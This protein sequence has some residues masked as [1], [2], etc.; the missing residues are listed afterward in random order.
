ML[1]IPHL[2]TC[3]PSGA[4]G[5]L[6]SIDNNF[7]AAAPFFPHFLPAAMWAPPR[8]PVLQEV[9]ACSGVGSPCGLQHGHHLCCGASLPLPPSRVLVFPLLFLILLLSFSLCLVFFP[10]LKYTFPEAP[11]ASWLRSSAVP[12][13]GSMLLEQR[14]PAQGSPWPLPCSPL[15]CPCLQILTAAP[16]T[17][18]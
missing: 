12:C 5:G 3:R 6:L 1:L 2:T 13:G 18:V 11:P 17:V 15:P 7:F 10:F 16:S 8:A 14:C 9:T 4:G